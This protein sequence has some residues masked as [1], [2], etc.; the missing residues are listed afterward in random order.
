VKDRTTKTA[1]GK[2]V[3]IETVAAQTGIPLRTVR[4]LMHQRKIPFVKFGHRTVFF[5]LAKVKAAI[6]A[7]EVTVPGTKA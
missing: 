4:T 2:L 5:E 7:F 6:A 3:N 1:E